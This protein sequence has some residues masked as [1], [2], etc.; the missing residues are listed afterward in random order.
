[1]GDT[2]EQFRT[3]AFF[4]D[5]MNKNL[6][7]DQQAPSEIRKKELN[8]KRIWKVFKGFISLGKLILKLFFVDSDNFN[9]E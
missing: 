5:F 4:G 7:H 9:D 2:L 1:M 8:K 6:E 3:W